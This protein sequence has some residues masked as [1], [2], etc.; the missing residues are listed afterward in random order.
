MGS[1]LL[2]HVHIAHGAW[3][4]VGDGRKVM[5]LLNEGDPDL[6]NL[7]RISVETTEN[8]A[9]HEQGTD[10]PGRSHSSA[11]PGRSSIE[12]TDWHQLGEDRF[13]TSVAKQIDDAAQSN[14]FKHIVI[15]MPPKALGELRHHL[16][17]DAISRVVKEINKDL[18]NHS[19][20][21][22]EK[23]LKGH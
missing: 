22:I 12:G 9:T 5:W 8:P 10:A 2:D 11:S 23:A 19:I 17:K 21:E 1:T 18:T 20:P 16:S 3:V 13:V 15:I 7:R 6:I 4:V 14:M